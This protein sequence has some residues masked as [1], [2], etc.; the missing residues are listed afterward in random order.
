MCITEDS[1]IAATVRMDVL[2]TRIVGLEAMLVD[3]H[4]AFLACD[5]DLALAHER[6]EVLEAALREIA[7]VEEC[8]SPHTENRMAS[9]CY[10]AGQCGCVYAKMFR[11]LEG[12]P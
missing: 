7:E 4:E 2:E 10:A 8:P 11:A 6:L 3:E 12:K 9:Q 1:L 5:R